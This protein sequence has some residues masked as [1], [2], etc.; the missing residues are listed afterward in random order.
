LSNPDNGHVHAFHTRH[1]I[2]DKHQRKDG[3]DPGQTR[4]L[5]S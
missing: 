3:K 5:V 4:Y 2:S 1:R